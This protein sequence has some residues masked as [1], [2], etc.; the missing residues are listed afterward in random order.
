MSSVWLVERGEYSDYEVVA[1][2]GTEVVARAFA[3]SLNG[4]DK[5]P[6]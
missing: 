4:G 5:E 1:I 3:A 6:A 2:L